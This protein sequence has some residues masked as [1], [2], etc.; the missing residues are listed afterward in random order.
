MSS[1]VNNAKHIQKQQAERTIGLLR[2]L[3]AVL[4][5]GRDRG[6]QLHLTWLDQNLSPRCQ[7]GRSLQGNSYRRL[8]HKPFT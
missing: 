6:R 1:T 7:R 5:G 8:A 2:G 4:L 3:L